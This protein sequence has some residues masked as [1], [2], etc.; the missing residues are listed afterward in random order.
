MV[1]AP[2]EFAI[3]RIKVAIP[4]TSAYLVDVLGYGPD[5]FATE[6]TTGSARLGGHSSGECYLPGTY[7]LVCIP[8]NRSD[9]NQATP[10]VPK[11]I[12]GALSP[13]TLQV[14]E[15]TTGVDIDPEDQPA[16]PERP[17]HFAT[18]FDPDNPASFN[19]NKL[20]ELLINND[21]L[22]ILNQ[23]RNKGR[24]LDVNPGDWY[25]T[26]SLNGFIYLSDFIVGLGATGRTNL[27]FYATEELAELT[28]H[29]LAIDS[30]S[31]FWQAWHRAEQ[32]LIMENTAFS[33]LEG[34][35]ALEGTPFESAEDEDN[36]F[37]L[38]L[39]VADQTGFFRQQDLKGGQ[40]E[41]EWNTIKTTPGNTS[42]QT[43]EYGEITYPGLLSEMKR[44]DGIYRLRAAQEIKLEKTH[45]ITVPQATAD[46]RTHVRPEPEETDGEAP[47]EPDSVEEQFGL[48]QNEKGIVEPLIHDLMADYQE[49]ELFFEGLRKEG[50]L[51]FFPTKAQ[52]EEAIG[53]AEP[54]PLPPL[55]PQQPEYTAIQDTPQDPEPAVSTEDIE[56][57]DG[58]Q[59]TLFKNSS[60]FLMQEDGGLVIG[61]G[62]GA[63]IRMNRG[64]VTIASAGDIYLQPGRDLVELT[65]GNRIMKVGDRVEITSTRDS[66]AI[67]AED[68]LHMLS[69]NSGAG[70]S[71]V[72]ENK[73]APVPLTEVTQQQLERGQPV[74]SG[75]MLKS[76]G[77]GISMLG[78]YIYGGGLSSTNSENGVNSERTHCDMMFNSG[79]GTI[80][81]SGAAM[82]MLMRNTLALGLQRSPT[83]IFVNGS[84]IFTVSNGA[85]YIS[86][87]QVS[88]TKSAGSV[89]IPE[90]TASG[91]NTRPLT[92]P[93]ASPN[94]II[95]GAAKI[96]SSLEV[97][98]A[99]GVAQSVGANLGCNPTPLPALS[100]INVDIPDSSNIV[101][102]GV[103]GAH[104]RA[105]NML[106]TLINQFGIA[107]EYGQR[108]MGLYF[109]NSGT[110][111]DP[112]V[113]RAANFSLLSTRWQDQLS[114]F[115]EWVEKG[116]SNAILENDSLPY[117]G[118]EAYSND[119]KPFK[120]L[121][122]F[123][124]RTVLP[125]NR[126]LNEY[127]VNVPTQESI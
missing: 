39:L 26:N 83:G 47:E 42:I 121:S 68:N 96:G 5:E 101:R 3:G 79:S 113:Y 36:E 17:R 77:A 119:N 18:E 86:A 28:S 67:K 6:V 100:R 9:I 32:V 105:E 73:A 71:T 111:G 72:I 66:I 85:Q 57:Y 16:D 64:K 48:S 12:L 95:E 41:G 106:G 49:Q 115:G 38:A 70:G 98:G 117:P 80:F 35:G 87:P 88:F 118:R 25:K 90:L 23:D 43:S 74:G 104:Q 8:Q 46:I 126:T 107:T 60:V 82:S 69:G 22:Q 40:V 19:N 2:I 75:I 125:D 31:Y 14:L 63:E 91:V 116:V 89:T 76:E 92:L 33:I 109:P 30:E 37:K 114:S 13:Y 44:M 123:D 93:S 108:I 127:K 81:M 55:N 99:V 62:Y 102:L 50:D 45:L 103:S 1:K 78:S 11:L 52:I 65:P 34:M 20:W 97:G 59:Q 61:D 21:T 54:I 53:G 122:K 110:E 84:S 124:D 15:D 24:P 29:N 7:V 94:V 120:T 10:D 4:Q 56:T 112:T 51:W 58:K 27:R